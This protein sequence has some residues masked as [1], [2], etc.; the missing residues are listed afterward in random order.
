MDSQLR[1]QLLARHPEWDWD[2]TN[3]AHVH[4]WY[5]ANLWHS[6]AAAAVIGRGRGLVVRVRHL[7]GA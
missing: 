5:G 2:V 6:G 7:R 1:T 4:L 3:Q